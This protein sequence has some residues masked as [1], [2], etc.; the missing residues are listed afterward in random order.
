MMWRKRA[1]FL[2]GSN[3]EAWSFRI[4][5]YQVMAHRKRHHEKSVVEKTLISIHGVDNLEVSEIEFRAGGQ[6]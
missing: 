6:I 2:P 3:F 4:A 5:K 1:E